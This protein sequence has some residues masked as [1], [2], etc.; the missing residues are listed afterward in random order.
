MWDTETG[1]AVWTAICL[2]DERHVTFGPTGEILHGHPRVI[3]DELVYLI[4]KA[5]GS[6]EILKPSEF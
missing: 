4:A 3:E 1:Q 2:R 5:D 6:S